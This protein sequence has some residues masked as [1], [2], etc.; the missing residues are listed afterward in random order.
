MYEFALCRKRAKRA[1]TANLQ[2]GL[3]VVVKVDTNSTF[4][5][6]TGLS[7]NMTDI[8]TSYRQNSAR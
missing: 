4:V 6:L 1:T 3:L 7:A 2:R 5:V 8:L